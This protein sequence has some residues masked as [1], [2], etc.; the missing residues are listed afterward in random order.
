MF[1][2]ISFRFLRFFSNPANFALGHIEFANGAFDLSAIGFDDLLNPVETVLKSLEFIFDIVVP[3]F[4]FSR[5]N[6]SNLFVNESWSTW[7]AFRCKTLESK[8][9][10]FLAEFVSKNVVVSGIYVILCDSELLVLFQLLWSCAGNT[11]RTPA[12]KGKCLFLVLALKDVIGSDRL[13]NGWRKSDESK[14]TAIWPIL[15]VIKA[16][17][18]IDLVNLVCYL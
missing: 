10:I 5:N 14:I 2:T 9:T 11:C 1:G 4:S 17:A 12:N 18:D 15:F 16:L 7:I 6:T 13:V 8:T 3:A